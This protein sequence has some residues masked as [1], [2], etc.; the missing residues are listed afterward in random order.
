MNKSNK[1]DDSEKIKIATK[2]NGSKRTQR[3][4]QD[5]RRQIRIIYLLADIQ[6]VFWF[7][8]S[9]VA[10]VVNYSLDVWMIA[11]LIGNIVG[12]VPVN[13]EPVSMMIPVSTNAVNILFLL[14]LRGANKRMDNIMKM[15]YG[16]G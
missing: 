2:K 16:V 12:A 10:C 4:S 6:V 7:V 15:L 1:Q 8:L 11:A 3:S 9:L 5:D 14:Q 13:F